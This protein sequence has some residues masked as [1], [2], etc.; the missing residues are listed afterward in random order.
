LLQCFFATVLIDSGLSSDASPV[1]L[2]SGAT[3]KLRF[4]DVD[5][6][7]IFTFDGHVSVIVVVTTKDAAKAAEVGDRQL[8][9]SDTVSIRRRLVFNQNMISERFDGTRGRIFLRSQ[10]SMGVR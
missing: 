3:Y 10:I 5:G 4:D 7:K 8:W 2:K 6:K 9:R 1:S